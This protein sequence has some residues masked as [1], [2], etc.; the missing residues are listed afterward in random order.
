[1]K[2][3]TPTLLFV[4][5]AA[6][7]GKNTMA[8]EDDRA[9]ASLDQMWSITDPTFGY[10]GLDFTFDYPVSNLIDAGQAYYEV[11]HTACKEGGT[12]ITAG[13]GF[14]LDTLIDVPAGIESDPNAFSA[15]GKT[16]TVPISIDV[17]TITASPGYSE[18]G[19]GKDLTA[20]IV[21]VYA[22]D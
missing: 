19:T 21:F 12:L 2:Y 6:A 22:L 8:Q 9:L 14:I 3:S 16:A 4:A 7:F 20:T 10:T 18:S 13:N 15:T 11:Y 17:S 1:M 5:A